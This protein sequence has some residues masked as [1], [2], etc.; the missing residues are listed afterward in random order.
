MSENPQRPDRAD[1]LGPI[2]PTYDETSTRIYDRVGRAAPQE[3]KPTDAAE[4]ETTVF[5]APTYVLDDPIEAEP[6]QLDRYE[7][8][9]SR[10]DGA[11]ARRGTIDF[12]L[13]L[14]RVLLGGWLVLA[15]LTTFF[16]LDGG[17]GLQGLEE[18]LSFLPAAHIMAIA[19]P[20]TQLAAGL[21]LIFGLLTPVA[22]ALALVV[23]AV[24]GAIQVLSIGEWHNPLAMGEASLFWFAMVGLSVV[25]LFTGPGLYSLDF[26]RGW[27]RRPLASSWVFFFIAAVIIGLAYWFGARPLAV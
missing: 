12:G 8:R 11:D 7:A 4:A 10:E 23:N 14:L 15:A 6:A 13:L 22:A 9:D 3:I 26:G 24:Y 16:R 18:E 17:Q 25:V 1:D 20:T 5:A 21:F 27:A 19:V 2:V